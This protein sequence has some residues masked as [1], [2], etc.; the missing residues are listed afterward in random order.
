M[1]PLRDSPASS[2]LSVASSSAPAPSGHHASILPL[3]HLLLTT[4]PLQLPAPSSAPSLQF[5]KGLCTTPTSSLPIFSSTQ[6]TW[7]FICQLAKS[8]GDFSRLIFL[9]GAPAAQACYSPTPIL[10]SH[11]PLSSSFSLAALVLPAGLPCLHPGLLH[12]L[13]PQNFCPGFLMPTSSP[14]PNSQLNFQCF[15]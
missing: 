2:V 6:A 1:L 15:H 11:A 10:L 4:A 3:T 9:L 8:S 5:W 13:P 7:I 14:S 12:P